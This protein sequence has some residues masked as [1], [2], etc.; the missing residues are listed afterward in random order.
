MPSDDYLTFA[1]GEVRLG[2]KIL[3][4]EFV[5]LTINGDVKFDH[6]EQDHMSGRPTIPKGWEAV[7]IRLTLDLLTDDEKSNCYAKLEEIND[8][9]KKADRRADPKIYTVTG[10]HLHAR[11]IRR[12]IFAGLYSDEDD[13]SDVIRATLCFLEH[14]PTVVKRE[15]QVNATTAAAG[16]PPV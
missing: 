6:V 11:G 1:D 5:S 14:L 12:V 3:P 8:L 10:R 7:D 16:T 9:F 2:N 15:K 13:Q 4:G